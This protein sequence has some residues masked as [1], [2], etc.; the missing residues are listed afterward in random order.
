[1]VVREV[2]VANISKHMS[3]RAKDVTKDLGR[4]VIVG[5]WGTGH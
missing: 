1:L 4:R 5:T 3:E 2:I